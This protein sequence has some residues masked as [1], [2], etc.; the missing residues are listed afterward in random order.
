MTHLDGPTTR[1][2]VDIHRHP[3]GPKLAAK[4]AEAGLYDPKQP[5]PQANARDLICDREFFDLDHAM[6]KQR[7]EGITLSLAS[8]GGEVDWFAQDLLRVGT[9]DALKFLNGGYVEMRDRYPGEFASMANAHALE[10]GCRPV[11]EEMITH[12]GAK[13]LAVASAMPPLAA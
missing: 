8:N 10:E 3:I 11:V 6:P 13:A 9:I 12:G 7:E 2:I 4:M 1:P 5:F